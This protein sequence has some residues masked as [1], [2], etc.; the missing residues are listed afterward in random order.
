MVPSVNQI[1]KATAVFVN[2]LSR[3]EKISQSAVKK[4]DKA[5][6]KVLED[7]GDRMLIGS[8]NGPDEL[9]TKALQKANLPRSAIADVILVSYERND[10]VLYWLDGH[11]H[12]QA[13]G[14]AG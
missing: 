7:A 14:M 1:D 10:K 8:V 13:E 2:L 3:Y 12:E 9:I 6:K 11:W 4:F 5:M